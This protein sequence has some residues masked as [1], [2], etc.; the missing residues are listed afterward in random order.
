M[1]N[2]DFIFIIDDSFVEP[3]EDPLNTLMKQVFDDVIFQIFGEDVYI[4]KALFK[5]KP[6][7]DIK[8]KMSLDDAVNKLYSAFILYFEKTLSKTP[9]D[10]FQKFN[11]IKPF[12]TNLN[13]S[14]E[15]HQLT[16]RIAEKMIDNPEIIITGHDLYMCIYSGIPCYTGN[17]NIN[18]FLLLSQKYNDLDEQKENYFHFYDK[19]YRIML[20]TLILLS[21]FPKHALEFSK[22]FNHKKL[23][24]NTSAYSIATDFIN[25]NSL[26]IF[27][28][29][30]LD[31]IDN[32]ILINTFGVEL[33]VE[34]MSNLKNSSSTK[35]KLSLILNNHLT[36]QQKFDIVLNSFMT[37]NSKELKYSRNKYPGYFEK[38]KIENILARDFIVHELPD[39]INKN[40][41]LKKY[42]PEIKEI[43]KDK[44]NNP[45]KYSK[46]FSSIYNIV[47]LIKL[48]EEKQEISSHIDKIKN[49][50]NKVKRI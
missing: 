35:N 12:F 14:E 6:F 4:E 1:E 19:E 15:L 31:K 43:L 25:K 23:L 38:I 40:N 21:N 28:E 16:I 8:L 11:H 45:D 18:S 32:E 33:L 29:F 20:K 37:F 13:Q 17:F 49:I 26:H 44:N 39:L 22:L 3:K 30:N 42:A 9:D 48:E 10:F 46:I 34:L 27:K 7:S 2:E 36:D 5:I 41:L 50:R 24:N 47:S